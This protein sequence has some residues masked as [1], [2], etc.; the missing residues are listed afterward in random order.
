MNEDEALHVVEAHP[1]KCSLNV[2]VHY[3]TSA[4]PQ[5]VCDVLVHNQYQA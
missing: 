2:T 1:L 5:L 4:I 3:Q